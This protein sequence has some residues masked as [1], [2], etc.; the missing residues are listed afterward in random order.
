[1]FAVVVTFTLH[2]DQSGAFMPL[3]L[4][5]AAQSLDLESACHQF[6][7]CTDPANPDT[8]FLYELYTDAAA[9][10]AHL[11]SAHFKAFDAATTQMIASKDVRTFAK[12]SQ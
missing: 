10:Q 7:V 4:G 8:V 5:N 11:A 1:M 3:M 9:F 2:P 6:D 12:V